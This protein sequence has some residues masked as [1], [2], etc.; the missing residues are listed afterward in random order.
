MLNYAGCF[1][2]T[3]TNYKDL[4]SYETIFHALYPLHETRACMIFRYIDLSAFFLSDR[5]S[6][7]NKHRALA[8]RQ[9]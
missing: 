1:T 3:L 9:F 2:S 5:M 6:Q 8:L 4:A 7:Q